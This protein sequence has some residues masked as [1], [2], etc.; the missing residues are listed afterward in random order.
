MGDQI[1]LT[2]LEYIRTYVYNADYLYAP[3]QA[4][5]RVLACGNALENVREI[6]PD[7]RFVEY[8]FPGIQPKKERFDWCSL[9]L[10]FS[11]YE[12]QWYL[13]GLIHSEWVI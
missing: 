3:E 6:F 8:Y 10:V 9:K 13:V 11:A 4:V 7:D 1:N 12:E 2:I 5:D